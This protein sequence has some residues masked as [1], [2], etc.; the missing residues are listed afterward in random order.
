[1]TESQQ[2]P[3]SVNVRP[4]TG[5]SIEYF[6]YFLFMSSSVLTWTC[7][8]CDLTLAVGWVNDRRGCGGRCLSQIFYPVWHLI[9]GDPLRPNTR[10]DTR[11]DTR[12]GRIMLSLHTSYV[13]T[14]ILFNKILNFFF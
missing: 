13:I 10:P 11:P 2:V 12:P 6:F 5:A 8:I 4:C 9:H 14:K 3:R 1:M 7:R